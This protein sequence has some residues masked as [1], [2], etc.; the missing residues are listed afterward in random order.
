MVT[1]SDTDDTGGDDEGKGNNDDDCGVAFGHQQCLCRAGQRPQL[2]MHGH[3]Q[4]RLCCCK[5]AQLLCASIGQSLDRHVFQYT[6]GAHRH[7]HT[8]APCRPSEPADRRLHVPLL[9]CD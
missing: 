7:R 8:H 5:K 3:G 9:N 4:G 1:D 6:A 2:R